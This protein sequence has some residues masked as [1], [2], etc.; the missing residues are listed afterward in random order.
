MIKMK[1]RFCDWETKPFEYTKENGYMEEHA[2]A[3]I[4]IKRKHKLHWNYWAIKGR[5]I[6]ECFKVEVMG[7][8][9]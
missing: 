4:H 3:K 8:E 6:R 7:I 1:C 2:R 5:V 9:E